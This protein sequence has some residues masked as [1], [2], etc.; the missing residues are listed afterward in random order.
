MNSVF[1][2]GFKVWD[3]K[4][5]NLTYRATVQGYSSLFLKSPIR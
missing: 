2:H 4:W 3:H 1:T 5:W